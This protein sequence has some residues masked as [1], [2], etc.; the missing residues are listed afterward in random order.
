MKNSMKWIVGVGVVVLALAAAGLYLMPKDN[1]DGPLPRTAPAPRG[2]AAGP[3]SATTGKT[4]APP[5]APPPAATEAKPSNVELLKQREDLDMALVDGSIRDYI[6]SL[7]FDCRD[8]KD[9]DEFMARVK[10]RLFSEFPPKTAQKLLDMVASYVDCEL[11]LQEMLAGFDTPKSEE[12]MIRMQNEIFDF[13]KTQ[14]GEELAEKLF[15]EEHRLVLYKIRSRAVFGDES[16]Y[17][18][19]KETR[20]EA[21]TEEIY[22]DAKDGYMTDK[23]GESRFQEKMLLYK[24][25][26]DEMSPDAKKARI[27]EWRSEYLPEEDIIKIEAAEAQAEA[28][29][30]RDQDYTEARN[31]IMN[32]AGLKDEEKEQQ[33]RQLQDRMYGDMA[34]S[35]RQ[36]EAFSREHNENMRQSLGAD[37]AG[38]ATD[39]TDAG[40]R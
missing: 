27:R 4:I 35:V 30:R 11:S 28:S 40:D 15:G 22:G 31:A 26:L 19:E 39:E 12:E 16:L 20:L 25:D 14:M 36:G 17:G 9:R 37:S 21:L 23:T 34:E 33:I 8:A 13:R 29:A 3:A 10:D 1:A 32:D 6:G 24:K 2:D 38:E 5:A 7:Y 18:R